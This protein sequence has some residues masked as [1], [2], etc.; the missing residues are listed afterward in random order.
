MPARAAG[1]ERV[2]TWAGEPLKA[3]AD[4]LM[5]RRGKLDT[6]AVNGPEDVALDWDA[7]DWR[8]H[9]QNV[10]RLRRRIFK[11]TRE[12]D[13]AKVRS[14]QKLMLGSWSNTLMSVRQVT[15]RNAG[16]RT[17]G[18]DGE[19]A[20]SSPQRADMAGRVHRSRASWDPMPVR[21]VYIPKANGKQRPLGI[22][23]LMDRCHQARV[24]NAL[25]PEWEAK[26]EARSYGF[27]PGRGC[28][29]AIGSLYSILKGP[30]AQRVWILDA[31]LSAAFDRIDHDRLLAAVG[32]FPA[33]G[34]I[35]DWLKAGVF[36]P[37][38]GFAPTEEGTPQGGVISPLLMNV[39]LHGL[40]EA[41]GV[42]YRQ[43][44]VNT[45][46]TVPGTPILVRYADDMVVCCCSRQQA[47]QVKARLA[48]WLAPRGLVFNEDKTRIV[49]L[50][51]GFDFLGFNLRRYRRGGRPGKLLIKPSQDAV[52]RIRRRLA[53]EIRSMRGS[54]A[55]ALIARLNPIIRGWAA[56]Y[57]GVVSSK[58][59]SALDSHVWCLTLSVGAPHPPHQV[60]E[61]D[62]APLLR[63]VQQVQE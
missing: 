52:R 31:D 27:R 36:E 20:L 44:G 58:L 16:R 13:W 32:D 18:I 38:K 60:E 12:Q 9:E 34:M 50:E 53:D 5:N 25:E 56:Y 49:H 54:N 48:H 55:M 41:A 2:L 46:T 15:Q 10:I 17:A 61:V 51:E 47:E 57:R 4:G 3:E 14:L 29:D 21:R 24:R 33:R 8:F 35:A 43:T 11:A 1:P 23:V 6:I 19:V 7:V 63:Q 39:A 40:E 62:R 28:A 42:R 30:R 26:F 37:G 45:G 22:P 59:F